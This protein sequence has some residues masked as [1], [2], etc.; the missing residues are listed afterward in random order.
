MSNPITSC[1]S[2]SQSKPG[3]N[4][5][6]NSVQSTPP[7]TSERSNEKSEF[8]VERNLYT[9]RKLSS[10]SILDSPRLV[11]DQSHE[12]S[13]KFNLIPIISLRHKEIKS[14]SYVCDFRI[15]KC[16]GL[17]FV[18]GEKPVSYKYH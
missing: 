13:G 2:P 3:F 15:R 8:A 12:F 4:F 16:F 1:I 18:I 17:A 14:T 7:C 10:F 6:L 11:E 5:P 9:G